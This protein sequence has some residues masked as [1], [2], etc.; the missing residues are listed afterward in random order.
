M[1]QRK[2]A[3]IDATFELFHA[4]IVDD[5]HTVKG[6]WKRTFMPKASALHL[7]LGC[8]KG[9]FIVAAAQKWPQVLFVGIDNS[10]VCI[11]R[12]AQKVVEQ[13]VRNVRLICADAAEIDTFFEPGEISQIYLNF[14]SPF[15]KKKHAEKRL[16]HL[17]YLEKYRALLGSAGLLEM[18]TDNIAYWKFSLVELE[19]AGFSITEKTDDLHQ[20]AALFNAVIAGEYDAR[21]T[22]R[23]AHVHFLRAVPAQK[24]QTYIQTDKLGLCEYLPHDIEN[25]EEIPY[26]MEDTVAN[27]RN[28]RANE[29]RR[30]ERKAAE[31]A[32]AAAIK[33]VAGEAEGV[34]KEAKA[35]AVAGEAVAGEAVARESAAEAAKSEATV[36][37]T[38]AVKEV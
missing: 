10:K 25:F 20:D 21:T 37:E 34:T 11:A 36:R 30:Q 9:D 29:R 16:T 8:G 28:R 6:A 15:P 17:H 19:I 14:N 35:E 23:G 18:R 24:P 38:E 4:P 13:N 1:R 5:A 22:K 32:E 26:G 33:A 12:T 31:E 3:N 27:M 7:D 2:P